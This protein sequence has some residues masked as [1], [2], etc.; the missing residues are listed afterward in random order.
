MAESTT[1]ILRQ[2]KL[3]RKK[4][5][6][7]R[8]DWLDAMHL[9][10]MLLLLF[11]VFL[12][13]SLTSIYS[14]T[15]GNIGLVIRQ[16]VFYGLG[17]AILCVVARLDIYLFRRVAFMLYLLGILLLLLVLLIGPEIKGARRW[18]DLGPVNFQPSEYVK[19][20]TLLALSWV[21]TYKPLPISSR[22]LV[23]VIVI[24]LIPVILIFMQPDLGSAL[25]LLMS[26]ACLVFLAGIGFR[27]IVIIFTV[28]IASFPF[29]W[30][31]VL[32]S[33][34]KRRLLSFLNPE[35]D[36]LGSGWSL[37]QSK[38]AIGT[39]GVLGKGW[40]KNQQAGLEFLPETH[41]DFIFSIFA[42][43]YGLIGVM[44]LMLLY[45][46]IILR[47]FYITL[48][49]RDSFER[50]FCTGVVFTFALYITINIGM[51]SGILP[52][53]GVPLPLVSYGG[54]SLITTL[55][56]FGILMSVYSHSRKVT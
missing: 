51:V 39:G 21:L 24:T 18:I 36:P 6:Y 26:S 41:T 3:L 11:L 17:L 48:R 56:A 1:H 52:V 16:A 42:E 53:V 38:I 27:S 30:H 44:G 46:M 23:Y 35:S 15:N 10:T 33:Y 55:A 49:A 4:R 13:L 45:L 29:L 34:H 28:F 5:F 40:G 14:A 31:Y 43:E 12:A 9:D 19:I 8:M 47:G 50:L 32:H 25:I 2:D 22:Q 7:L 54:T 37:I 20:V